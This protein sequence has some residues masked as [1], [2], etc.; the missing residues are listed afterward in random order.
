MNFEEFIKTK[1]VVYENG[2]WHGNNQLIYLGHPFS[3]RYLR[4]RDIGEW[5]FEKA[6]ST[7]DSIKEFEKDP[8]DYLKMAG[9]AGTWLIIAMD[10]L[11]KEEVKKRLPLLSDCIEK[12]G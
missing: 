4:V 1:K 3:G 6:I 7:R 8:K 9:V 10:C 12:R 11:G 2:K 5:A